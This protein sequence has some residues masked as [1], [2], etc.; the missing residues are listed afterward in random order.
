MKK[1]KYVVLALML[2]LCFSLSGCSLSIMDISGKAQ[3]VP[4]KA[5]GDEEEIQKALEEYIDSESESYLSNQYKLKY[6]RLG[7]YRTAF[8]TKDI[9]SDGTLE[10]IVFYTMDNASDT[11]HVNY[12]NKT[13]YGWQSISDCS[14][15]NT[16]IREVKF[17]DM[18]GDGSNEM[19]IGWEM[20]TS[21]DNNLC[22][23]RLNKTEMTEIGNYVYTDILVD[24]ISSKIKKDLLLFRISSTDYEVNAQLITVVDG[25]PYNLGTVQ[26]DGYIEKMDN[27]CICA[28]SE[29]I[30]GVFFD[31]YKEGTQVVT[32]LITWDGKELLAPFYDD[33]SNITSL[34]ARNSGL[35]SMD[36]DGDGIPEWPRSEKMA[37][38]SLMAEEDETAWLTEWCSW[39]FKNETVVSKFY[40]VTVPEDSYYLRV[41]EDWLSSLTAYYNN[42]MHRLYL[43]TENEDD[44]EIN[45]IVLYPKDFLK[46]AKE[47]AIKVTD[48]EKFTEIYIRNND[49][50]V[51]AQFNKQGKLGLDENGILYRLKFFK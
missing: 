6:P 26:L 20:G 19:L 9:D 18:D 21:R 40:S 3:L 22:L 24:N 13:N 36:V 42:R 29:T 27:F 48:V 41:E 30:K 31:G 11:I 23:Y 34:T 14:Y 17:A 39:D 38:S 10:A 4:P 46:V 16:S 44:G 28:G 7:D 43:T 50:Y 33:G 32:E 35:A 51:M 15:N 45:E 47:E 8:I 2:L 25:A 1:G 5:S 37:E 49:V 12:F